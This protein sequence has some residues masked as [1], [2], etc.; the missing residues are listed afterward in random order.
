M[1]INNSE[2]NVKIKKKDV[3]YFEHLYKLYFPK[4][5]FFANQYLNNQEDAKEIAQET[6]VTLW[7][8]RH[9]LKNELNIQSYILTITRN[10]CL[11][12][13]RKRIAEQKY[14]NTLE[15]R[16]NRTNYL[17][18]RDE[19]ANPIHFQELEQL[20]NETIAEM[21][22]KL[23]ETF[24]LNRIEEL[25]YEEIAK[26]LGVSV[27]TIEYRISKALFLFKVKL[28]EY[29]SLISILLQFYLLK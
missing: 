7:E 9:D 10:K 21:S 6:F 29:L 18:L 26:Q 5:V 17:A 11:N 1:K 24:R 12:I 19:S 3:T 23:Q 25:T 8:K 28:R 2:Y 20:I 22:P 13:L 15:A 27:K 4:S 14:T 16:E